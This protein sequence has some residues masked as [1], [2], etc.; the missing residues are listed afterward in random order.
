MPNGQ[1]KIYIE[2]HKDQLVVGLNQNGKILEILG[3]I[4]VTWSSVRKNKTLELA[5]IT[6]DEVI[7]PAGYTGAAGKP[8]LDRLI[9]YLRNSYKAETGESLTIG[10]NRIVG[11]LVGSPYTGGG[12]GV[13]TPY[14]GS[15]QGAAT[16]YT[17]GG[18]PGGSPYTAAGSGPYTGGGLSGIQLTPLT[19]TLPNRTEPPGQGV[20][21]GILDTRL[22]AHPNLAGRYLASHGTLAAEIPARPPDQE[23]HATFIAG[24]VLERA[25]NAN[26]MVD[27]VLD[28]S[29]ISTSSWQ[30]ATK[31]AG[32]AEAGVKVLNISFGAATDDDNPPLVLQRAVEV[33]GRRG[34]IVVAAAGNNGP[35]TR[36][37][38]PAALAENDQNVVAVGAGTPN[39]SGG[40]LSAVFSP[41]APW[42][43][44][45]APGENIYSTY[46]ASGYAFWN[47]T[48]FAA[49]AVSGAIAFLV[50]TQGID[51]SEAVD[52]L[53]TPPGSRKDPRVTA[54]IDDIG[55]R[56]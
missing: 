27:H 42:I 30:V 9:A 49:A 45:I 33:L 48:S 32:F 11:S 41:D 5:L 38:W 8:D 15:G 31:M 3:H 14:T 40:F 19:G 51:A 2:A 17:G 7:V 50:Q 21:V 4:H 55:P 43:G 25:P 29:D 36:K 47:G 56:A 20:G 23:A 34:V 28:E 24:V 35:D 1:P 12:E 16:P 44:L 46:K 22:F 13:P 54:V 26:L 39:G 52:W 6:L 18:K 37:I 10:K 53:N